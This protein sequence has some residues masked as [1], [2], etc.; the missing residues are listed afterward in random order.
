MNRDTAAVH[1]TFQQL[2]TTLRT[3]G[4]CFT[5]MQ[6]LLRSPIC[7]VGITATSQPTTTATQCQV[8]G[9]D[10]AEKH[11]PLHFNP[12]WAPPSHWNCSCQ[13]HQWPSLPPNSMVNSKSSFH[14]ISQQHLTLLSVVPLK[15]FLYLA[16]QTLLSWSPTPLVAPSHTPYLISPITG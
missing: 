8:F 6:N 16:F 2:A 4:T 10:A 7:H 12:I 14:S 11:S 15:D 9:S 1:L 3:Q 5:D 13:S